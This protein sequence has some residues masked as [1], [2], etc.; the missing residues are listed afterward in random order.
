MRLPGSNFLAAALG[1]VVIRRD[2]SA[3]GHLS[4]R[5]MQQNAS[6]CSFAPTSL[7]LRTSQSERSVDGRKETAV[8][9]LSCESTCGRCAEMDDPR[10]G[11]DGGRLGRL[12]GGRADPLSGYGGCNRR[13]PA[14]MSSKRHHVRFSIWLYGYPPLCLI[15]KHARLGDMRRAA[16]A[17]TRRENHRIG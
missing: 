3:R 7:E 16:G 10:P 9:Y 4:R 14:S 6:S 17:A 1:E 13:G 8:P 2:G 11:G 15:Y 12:R 5:L